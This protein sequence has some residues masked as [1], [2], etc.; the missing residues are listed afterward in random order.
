MHVPRIER[1][2]TDWKSVI[3]PLNYTCCN[4]QF[5]LSRCFVIILYAHIRLLMYIFVGDN[6]NRTDISR[7]PHECVT[8]ITIA[9]YIALTRN[10]TG[11]T[12]LATEYSAT[13]P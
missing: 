10:R 12:P 5:P 9:P 7:V 2:T 8:I 11:V 6:R 4:V 13:E 1:G 3:I